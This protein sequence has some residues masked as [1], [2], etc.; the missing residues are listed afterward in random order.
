[1]PETDDSNWRERMTQLQGQM[2]DL[3][4]EQ[5][6][7]REVERRAREAQAEMIAQAVTAGIRAAVADP[8]MWQAGSEAME[9]MWRDKAGGWL[10][11][12]LKALA[13]RVAWVAAIGLAVYAMGG[14]SAL[15]ALIKGAGGHGSPTP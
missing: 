4:N 9:R 15:M 3:E 6:M 7:E 13:S 8:A 1:M 10:L 5:R 14:W 12:N 2:R 11:G